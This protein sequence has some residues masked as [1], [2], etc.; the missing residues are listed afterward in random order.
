MMDAVGHPVID[1]VRRQFG[2]LHL[3]TLPVG[4]TRD[5]TKV[6][7]GRVLTLSRSGGQDAAAVDD[8]ETEEDRD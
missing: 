7:L 5:L 1:L 2:P 8:T 4:Q 3:G 6:E